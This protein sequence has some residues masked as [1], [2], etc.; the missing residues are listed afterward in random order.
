MLSGSV[1]LNRTS[2][3]IKYK[4]RGTSVSLQVNYLNKS[5]DTFNTLMVYP[6]YYV[7]F[8]SVVLSTCIILF[9]E[10]RNIAAVDVVTILG[11]FLVIVVG[12]AMLHL[13]KD[14]QVC[15]RSRPH[16][17][18]AADQRINSLFF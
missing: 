8:T 3:D 14:L 1:E 5:L 6:I 16:E 11:A 4:N 18:E 7:L 2:G 17:G 9:Q 10:W 12:V 13:F 15:G